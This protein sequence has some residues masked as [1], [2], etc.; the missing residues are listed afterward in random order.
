MTIMRSL[1]RLN[2]HPLRLNS[3]AI[4]T[5]IFRGCVLDQC[6]KFTQTCKRGICKANDCGFALLVLFPTIIFLTSCVGLG[7]R[8]DGV[9]PRV[10]WPALPGW[11]EDPVSEAWPAFLASCQKLQ[12]RTDVW[13][14]I[15][16]DAQTITD[17]TDRTVRA[18]FET[19]FIV[20]QMSSTAGSEG[21][22]TGYYEPLLHG[23]LKP[24][25]RFRFPLYRKP[26]DLLTVQLG[27]LYPELAGKVVRARV[28]NDRVVPY[29]SRA[30][31]DNGKSLL[32]G[33][34]L[35][36]VD[37]S[38]DLFFLHIQGS[39]RV[40]LTDGKELAVGYADQNGH[41]YESIGAQLIRMGELEA[42]AVNMPSIKSW[43]IS[44]PS[45]AVNLLNSNPSY[46]FFESRSATASGPL[47]ALNVPLV[48]ERSLAVDRRYVQLGYPVWINTQLPD[49]EQPYRRLMMAQDTGG[50]IK[51]PIRADVF[52][53]HGKR[54][55]DV[56]GLM[57]QGGE[58]YIILPKELA[59]QSVYAS[60]KPN[61]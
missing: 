30:E 25:A 47:G 22:I 16:R 29:Y 24:T 11:Q 43:L 5:G 52:F 28:K 23:S 34:E 1:K 60:N 59:D 8:H 55:E 49:S 32:K 17:P 6:V 61:N 15:C 7:A 18:F 48:A 12:R 37:N 44:Y 41:P 42:E 56:A 27:S 57:K 3:V 50:A 45:Q 33:H 58:L 51:G 40:R 36:W 38:V 2:S 20:R 54:A 13:S 14:D 39:G 35:V 53:G 31:I 10:S 4:G 46:I 19:R 9:G 21:L 26:D